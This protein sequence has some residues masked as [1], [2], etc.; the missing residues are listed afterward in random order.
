MVSMLTRPESIR[1]VR[2]ASISVGV[3]DPYQR[4]HAAAT[5]HLGNTKAGQIGIMV[6]VAV[7]V[8]ND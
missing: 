7:N 1:D 6:V 8:R 5:H 4:G 3:L 2:D